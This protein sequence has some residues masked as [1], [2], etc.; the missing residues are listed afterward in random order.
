MRS[1]SAALMRALRDRRAE[2]QRGILLFEI[3]LVVILISLLFLIALER[4]LPLRGQAEEAAVVASVGAMQSAL[5]MH[6]A[7]RVLHEGIESLGAF[8][9]SNPVELM[10]RP[11]GGYIGALPTV[12][13]QQL[14]GGQWAFARDRGVLVYRVRY[15]QY[16]SGGLMDPPRAEWRIGLQYDDADGARQALRGVVLEPLAEADWPVEP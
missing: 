2:S 13:A 5:G 12:D 1:P 11:P 8:E 4:L 16:F 10:S 3:V 9:R 7:E 6:V 15:P 14:Q